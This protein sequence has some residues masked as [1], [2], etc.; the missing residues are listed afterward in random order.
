[1]TRNMADATHSG[2]PALTSVRGFQ[3]VA[4]YDTGT[5]D[6]DWTDSDW[7]LFPGIP[8]V[9]ID[10]GFTGSPRP[11]AIVRDCERGAWTLAEAIAAPWTAERRTLYVGYPY[12]AAEA[13]SAGW[14]GD[15][16]LVAPGWMGAPPTVPGCN[17]VAVQNWF[18]GSYDLSIVYDDSWPGGPAPVPSVPA[19]Q[20]A[21]MQALPELREGATGAAVRSV[22]GLCLARGHVIA[23]DG[24]FGP[25]TDS[26]VRSV[27]SAARIGVDGIV[28]PQTW[29]ALL[30]V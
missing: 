27:Q 21:M 18:L 10:Q 8:H 11:E 29:P 15:L 12:T 1:M 2:V 6:I 22:Q 25:Q 28:G 26:A 24:V 14:R 23:C 13:V 9:T 4:G 5:P 17:V 3:L 19:W 20:E 30:G 16:W 7:A